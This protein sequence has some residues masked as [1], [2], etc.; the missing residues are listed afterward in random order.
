MT[1]A[2]AL[3]GDGAGAIVLKAEQGKARG[4][5]RILANALH[6]TAAST[7]SSMSMAARPRPSRLASCAWRERRLQARRGQ[8]GGV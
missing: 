7:T 6:P 5:P 3:N 8:H 1:A 2:P 4:R